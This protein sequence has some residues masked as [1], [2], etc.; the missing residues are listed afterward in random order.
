[1]HSYIA[2]WQVRSGVYLAHVFIFTE[3]ISIVVCIPNSF[4][5][6]RSLESTPGV[7]ESM[8]LCSLCLFSLFLL[9]Y[10][11]LIHPYIIASQQVHQWPSDTPVVSCVMVMSY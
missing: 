2:G 3:F 8:C 5:Y 6:Y 7:S 10:A 1:M 4:L 9:L 11:F